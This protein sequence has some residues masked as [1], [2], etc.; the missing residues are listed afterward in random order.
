M[1][2]HVPTKAQNKIAPTP[3]ARRTNREDIRVRAFE[4]YQRRSAIGIPGDPETDWLQA[5]RELNGASPAIEPE[6]EIR[7]RI[8]GE[9]LLAGEVD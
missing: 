5:E 8:R 6:I 4:I 2:T 3:I 7:S 1:V 9:R